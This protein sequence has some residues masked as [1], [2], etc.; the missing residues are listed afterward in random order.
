MKPKESGL[1]DGPWNELPNWA[2]FQQPVPAYFLSTFRY[3]GALKVLDSYLIDFLLIML[4]K[5]QRF[6]SF[7]HINPELLHDLHDVCEL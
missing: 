6:D 5:T 1:Y 4:G 3:I 7:E 2:D